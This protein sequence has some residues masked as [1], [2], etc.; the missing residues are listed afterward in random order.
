MGRRDGGGV[1]RRGSNSRLRGWWVAL[2]LV[3]TGDVSFV[4]RWY[5]E[6]N[7]CLDSLEGAVA[8]LIWT[9][10]PVAMAA[11]VAS[12]AREVVLLKVEGLAAATGY[13]IS[14]ASMVGW[15]VWTGYIRR[16]IDC[17]TAL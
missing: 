14:I 4:G 7:A 15:N 6:E 9:C 11:G 2:R 3:W 17:W 8:D 10:L 1:A 12:L 13:G 16:L 5:G